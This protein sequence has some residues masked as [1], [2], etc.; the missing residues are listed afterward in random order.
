MNQLNTCLGR[1][2]KH[3]ILTT[4]MLWAQLTAT[5]QAGCLDQNRLLGVNLSGAEFSSKQL[6]GTLF[7]DY[8]YPSLQDM[9]YFKQAGMNIIRLP[10]RWERLQRQIHGPLEASDLEQ[11]QR[12]V[13]WAKELDLCV[14]LDMHN[15]GSY[16][17]HPIGSAEVPVAAF[18]DVWRRLQEVFDDPSSTAFGL[19]N[20]PAAIPVPAWLVIAQETV[21]AL[22]RM[23]ARNLLMVASGRWSGAHEWA[24]TFDGV[25]AANAFRHFQDPLNNYVIELHQYAD[26][27]FS[28]TGSRCIEAGRLRNL[29]LQV[30]TWAIKEKKRFFLGEFG[31]NTSTECMAALHTLAESMQNPTAWLGWTYWSAGPWWGKYPYS[32]Q[33]TEHREAMQ[34]TLLRNFL[35]K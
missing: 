16:F 15:Y 28:G 1:M 22:R 17:G 24:K 26:A 13:G 10:F 31:A 4:F 9:R 6:P 25:S 21:L 5:A 12:I 27:N 20:E 29:M 23:G 18:I 19:M 8:H 30:T 35:P 33:P 14:L 11:L 2:L 3:L 32:I 7:K 34:L